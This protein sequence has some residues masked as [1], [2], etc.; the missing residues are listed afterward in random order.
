MRGKALAIVGFGLSF[1]IAFFP[2][3]L[4][5]LISS[6]GWEKTLVFMALFVFLLFLPLSLALL[7]KSDT[8][9]LP[10]S[11]KSEAKSG[12]KDSWTRKDV[13]KVP[14]FYFA[15]PSGLLIPFFSTGL[16]IHIGS[17]VE[18]KGWTMKL[19]ATCF[20][21]SA[22]SQ[23][24]GSFIMGPLVDRFTANR[25]FPF[26]LIPYAL[27]LGVVAFNNHS[28]AAPAWFCL[29]GI[30]VGC[31]TVTM[32]SLWAEIFGTES[33]GAIA[34]LVGSMGVF[35]TAIS[36]FLFGWLVEHGLNIN[37]L[38]LSGVFLT[39]FVSVL[40]FI[41]PAPKRHIKK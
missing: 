6:F 11:H 13:L 35:A 14:F 23:R 27:A 39:I 12:E 1:G 36:P 9:Q 32:S 22:V 4:E 16:I 3:A 21:I 26:V 18:Y 38:F 34:S 25:L 17:I 7:K 41:A 24:V 15:V 19:I 20:I 10:P 2:L 31:M 40:A 33:L 37:N 5:N 8:F 29:G 30:S 28:F